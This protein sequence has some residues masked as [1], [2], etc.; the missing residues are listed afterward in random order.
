MI[1]KIEDGRCFFTPFSS[2]FPKVDFWMRF[3]R[4]LAPFWRLLLSLALFCLPLAPFWHLFGHFLVPFGSILAPFGF[5][6]GSFWLLLAPCREAPA[7][8]PK[9][10]LPCAFYLL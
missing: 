10:L 1:K 2:P 8:D 7:N 3:G 4:S 6:L 9:G 5:L